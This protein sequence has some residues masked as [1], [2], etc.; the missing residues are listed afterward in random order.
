MGKNVLW[1]TIGTIFYFFCQWVLTVIVLYLT[2]SYVIAGYLAL[3]MTLSSSYSTIALFNMR[4]FQV[5]DVKNEFEDGIYA[6]SRI[7]TSSVSVACCLAASYVAGNT[8]YQ[9]ECILAYMGIRVVEAWVDVLH[10]VDQRYERYDIIGKS[11]II[12]G[13]LTTGLFFL[14]LKYTN[15]LLLALICVFISTGTVALVYDQKWVKRLNK[16]FTITFSKSVLKLLWRCVPYVLITYLLS[17]ENLLA[18]Q[19][20][21]NAFGVEEQGIYSTIAAPALIVQVC[22]V[23]IFNP[24]LPVFSKFWHN[25]DMKA[26]Q[27]MLF[28]LYISL[29]AMSVIVTFGA[30]LFGRFGLRLLYGEEILEYFNIFIPIVWVTIL[31]ATTWIFV[32]ILTAMRK[33]KALI[34]G[35]LC[36]FSLYLL[37]IH[38]LIVTYGKNGA[39]YGQI[40]ALIIYVIYMVIV[41][42]YFVKKLSR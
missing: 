26:F 13:I 35:I 37:L 19:F 28:K 16:D 36:D 42:E 31:T 15:D 21:Q 39:S 12:R 40:I 7:V 32:S 3:A 10:G 29:A 23:V 34:L 4:S 18:K 14:V 38:Y 22:S 24:F 20:L 9:I 2:T 33:I 27:N 11:Y 41:C 5:S 8:T 25:G 17:Q 30:A 6:A 1:N